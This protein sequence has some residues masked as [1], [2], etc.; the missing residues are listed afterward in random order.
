MRIRQTNL[1]KLFL[2]APTLL[3]G[4]EVCLLGSAGGQ[5]VRVILRSHTGSDGLFLP[6]SLP[7]LTAGSLPAIVARWRGA[8]AWHP[9]Y[10]RDEQAR[11]CLNR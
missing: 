3:A 4:C 10:T 1:A 8:A 5:E 9:S 6:D 2:L 11:V 7:L